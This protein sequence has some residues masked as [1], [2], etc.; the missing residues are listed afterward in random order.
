MVWSHAEDA[1]RQV[2]EKCSTVDTTRK[3]QEMTAN[4]NQEEECERRNGAFTILN[5]EAW[6][7]ANETFVLH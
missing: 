7:T 2:A 6:K 4:N 1:G 5:T 3:S